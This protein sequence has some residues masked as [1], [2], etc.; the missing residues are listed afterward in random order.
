MYNMSGVQIIIQKQNNADWKRALC[1]CVSLQSH[2]VGF[3][4][5]LTLALILSKQLMSTLFTQTPTISHLVRRRNHFPNYRLQIRHTEAGTQTQQEA[6]VFKVFSCEIKNFQSVI[7]LETFLW[8]AH[9]FFS[10]QILPCRTSLRICVFFPSLFLPR[11]CF[12]KH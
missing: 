11:S 7:L 4:N 12:P 3:E 2:Y 5:W 6:F 1:N 9:I 8:N 10:N